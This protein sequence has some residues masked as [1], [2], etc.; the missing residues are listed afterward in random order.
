MARRLWSIPVA[1]AAAAALLFLPTGGDRTAALPTGIELRY[2]DTGS[3]AG[4]TV[5]LL[6]GVTDSMRSMAG[7]AAALAVCR[8]DLRLVSLDFR[9]HGGSSM[10]T[11]AACRSNPELCFRLE[12]FAADVL[13]LLDRLEIARAH[14]V[15]HSLGSLVA[16]E[17]A[18]RHPERVGRLV[19]LATTVDLRGNPALE[20][21]LIGDLLEQRWRPALERAGLTFPADAYLLTPSH[22][23]PEAARWMAANWVTEAPADP[24]LL[25]AIVA[26]TC[27]VRLGT[28][29]GTLQALV[30]FDHRERLASLR[31]PT[32]VLWPIQ[33][34][35]F[36]APTQS[37]V[38]AALA[39][40][41]ERHGT[42]WA[43]KRYGERE[44]GPSGRQDDL[45]HNFV[46]SAAG[47][48]ARDIGAF[49]REGGRPTEELSS[50]DPAGAPRVVSVP[51][52][53]LVLESPPPADAR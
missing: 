27:A 43:W 47:A 32:L 36:G 41:T 53:A 28:W 19:L 21:H 22:A 34:S 1:A 35:M 16:Q 14:L 29:I 39:A 11:A 23:D 18:L 49:L 12:D 15:G 33:D 2:R 31:A 40:A 4:E 17:L 9:G 25:D 48:I 44:L 45:G 8:P 10:P 7:V 51:A 20:G 26:E 24:A 50:A 42:R 3:R 37:S 30:G 6:H 13:A 38:R 52:G 5:V 46:W